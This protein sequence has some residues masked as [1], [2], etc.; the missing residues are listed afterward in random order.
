MLET[1][2]PFIQ[3]T[4][5]TQLTNLVWI[6]VGILQQQ[7]VALPQI[8]QSI[9]GDTNAESRV[10]QI[11]RWLMNLRV[12]VWEC[13]HPLLAH[14]LRGWQ[15]QDITVIVDGVMVFGDRLQIFRLSL[16]HGCRAVPIAWKV[17]VGKGLTTV[18][19]LEP[20][21]KPAADFLR[22]R[23]K[24]VTL[25]A[26]RG[27]R[28]WDW[29]ALCGKLGWDYVIR[30]P[31]NTTVTLASGLQ[32]RID[33]LGVKKGQRRYF[34]QVRLTLEH[35]GL[36]NLSVTWT[37]G[38]GQNK[39]EILAVMSRRPANKARL[40]RYGLRMQIEESFRDDKSGGFD[41]AH[42]R[43]QHPERLERLL[44]A[45]AIATIWCHELGE[46]CLKG[47]N[48][49]QIDPGWEREL[50]LFQLGLRWLHRC[51]AIAVES[52]PVFLA[53]LTPIRLLPVV[54]SGF[55]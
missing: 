9:P 38:E 13:Y 25:L 10:T 4:Y 22:P 35:Q 39:P 37:E 2:A 14:T 19:C 20:M 55:P 50:S 5:S 28:D 42:T 49:R 18:D 48:R 6:T 43:L 30:I 34:Q 21:L 26:D 27:F 32:C 41:L 1:I 17:V 54:K 40:R 7:S 36:S 23:V 3:T 8:A 52:I 53:H 46:K 24:S 47:G 51:L 45:V 29:A 11:R 33:E 31:C 16:V 44:L 12:Q 15:K